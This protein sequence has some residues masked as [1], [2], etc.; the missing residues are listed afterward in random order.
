MHSGRAA[1]GGW[2]RQI[3]TQSRRR[4]KQSGSSS[5]T[6][7]IGAGLMSRGADHEADR[8]G[9]AS[10]QRDLQQSVAKFLESVRGAPAE[11]QTRVTPAVPHADV[12][13]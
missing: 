3:P 2:H 5:S 4:V 12:G 11:F 7:H 6:G 8:L 9:D 13:T 10:R 1:W